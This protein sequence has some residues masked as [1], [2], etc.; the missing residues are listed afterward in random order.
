V[1]FNLG[2]KKKVFRGQISRV[3]PVKDDSHLVLHQKFTDEEVRCYGAASSSCF[4]TYQASPF[5]LL[6]SNVS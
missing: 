1:D 3:G 4:S 2:N 6:P 5:A